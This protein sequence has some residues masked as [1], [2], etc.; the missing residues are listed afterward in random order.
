LVHVAGPVSLATRSTAA[1]AF[2]SSAS[3][4]GATSGASMR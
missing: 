2:A 3:M 4:A 1:R